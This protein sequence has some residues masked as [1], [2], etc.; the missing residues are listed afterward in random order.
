MLK[1]LPELEASI[2]AGQKTQT[3]RPMDPQPEEYKPGEYK[4]QWSPGGNIYTSRE[5]MPGLA[6]LAPYVPGD[7]F[8][9]Q[10]VDFEIVSVRVER[11][12]EI[13]HEDAVA[14][15]IEYDPSQMDGCKWLNGSR[16]IDA[17]ARLWDAIYGDGQFEANGWVFVYT[18]KKVE[19]QP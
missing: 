10:G 9:V 13:S 8:Q 16:A 6:E 14:E 18:F 11:V 2:L 5:H 1:F 7:R 12:G 3:R 19:G 4:W 17:F 15:G